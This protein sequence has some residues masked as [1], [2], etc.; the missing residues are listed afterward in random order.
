M[1][2]PINNEEG[3]VI[4]WIWIGAI[5]IVVTISSLV[6][7]G[8]HFYLNVNTVEKRITEQIKESKARQEITAEIKRQINQGIKLNKKDSLLNERL[9]ALE[10]KGKI[11]DYID[12]KVQEATKQVNEKLDFWG[13]LGLP[14]GTIALISILV[15]FYSRINPLLD[16]LLKE[17][18]EKRIE[19]LDEQLA[20]NQE[21]FNEIIKQ[22]NIINEIEKKRKILIISEKKENEDSYRN[23]FKQLDFNPKNLDYKILSNADFDSY[24]NTNPKPQTGVISV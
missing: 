19:S 22:Q 4:P 15:A 2:N 17:K 20:K 14:F 3:L 6:Y 9:K 1:K 18:T 8:Y 21:S 16:Q 12:K 7:W 13:T 23:F 11:D 24:L 10:E 5:V